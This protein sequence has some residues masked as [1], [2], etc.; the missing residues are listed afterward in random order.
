MSAHGFQAI[1][2]TDCLQVINCPV[3]RD[4]RRAIA[5]SQN[6]GLALRRL[7]ASLRACA[8]CPLGMN[9]PLRVDL[10]DQVRRAVCEAADELRGGG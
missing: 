9:C 10:T 8:R 2:D 4:A 3:R 6:L 5:L 7:R 1:L